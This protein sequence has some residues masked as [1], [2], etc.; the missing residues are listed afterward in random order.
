M[1]QWQT[2]S[3]AAGE[4]S[5]R[6]DRRIDR[7]IAG[8][9]IFEYFWHLKMILELSMSYQVNSLQSLNDQLYMKANPIYLSFGSSVIRKLQIYGT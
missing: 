8:E 7:R 9:S 6:I 4:N 2:L 1:A 3:Y 5:F